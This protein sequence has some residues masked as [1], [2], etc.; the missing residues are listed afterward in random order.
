VYGSATRGRSGLDAL[1]DGMNEAF[2]VGALA[3]AVPAL[4][5]AVFLLRPRRAQGA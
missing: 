1:V 5:V 4:L 2:F 3:F